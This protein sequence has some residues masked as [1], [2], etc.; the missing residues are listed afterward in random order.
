[1]SKC[2]PS[3][4][5]LPK[6]HSWRYHLIPSI[7]LF[8]AVNGF[9]S[10]TY[11]LLHK[12]NVKQPYRM[13]NK[14]LVNTQMQAIVRHQNIF[15]TFISKLRS[16]SCHNNIYHGITSKKPKKQLTQ[17]TINQVVDQLKN[18]QE[19]NNLWIHGFE[20]LKSCIYDYFQDVE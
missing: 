18:T 9:T 16:H 12:T 14:R 3:N 5:N 13:T 6:L 2:S 10:E 11:E 17:H 20:N 15:A 8:G 7:R 4:L 1:M 19:L